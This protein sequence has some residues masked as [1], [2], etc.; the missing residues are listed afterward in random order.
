MEDNISWKL[1]DFPGVSDVT[2]DCNNPQS[3]SDTT[4]SGQPAHSHKH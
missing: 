2:S 1:E 3:V 4:V